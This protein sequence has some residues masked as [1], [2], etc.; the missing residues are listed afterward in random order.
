MLLNLLL[1]V[2]LR[3]GPSITW[4]GARIYLVV[5]LRERVAASVR[6]RR[7]RQNRQGP[8]VP[9]AETLGRPVGCLPVL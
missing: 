8:D 2:W 5:P 9:D 4:T 1:P 6:G 7:T 3:W